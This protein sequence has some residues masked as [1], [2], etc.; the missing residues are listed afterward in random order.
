MLTALRSLGHEILVVGPR[1]A[2]PARMGNEIGWAR[3]LKASLPRALYEL[4]ELS[5]SVIALAQI[6]RAIRHFRPDVI[7]ERYNLFLVAGV[8]AKRRYR[9]PLVLEVNAPVVAERSRFGGL[10][11]TRLARWS[12]RFMWCGADRVLPVTQVLA[13]H[14][15]AVGVPPQRVIVIPNGVNEAHFAAASDTDA[16]KAVI[17]LPGRRV[18]GFTGFIREWHGVDRVIL[19]MASPA[20]P[21][22]VHL[23]IVGDGP[24][25][26]ELEALA[27][28]HRV[29]SRVTFTGVVP[30]ER[31]PEY[32]AAFDVALQPA[33]VPYAS[34]LKVF[35]YLA[36]GKAILAPRQPNIEEILVDGRNALLFDPA[37]PEALAAALDRIT[38]DST[39]RALLAGGAARTI[40]E[41]GLTW[42]D[43]AKR[44]TALCE[45]LSSETTP[46]AEDA[47]RPPTGRIGRDPPRR[48]ETA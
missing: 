17:G 36:L 25:R 46:K 34:P 48:K 39:L 26:A 33:V 22:D 23:L 31:V 35:E 37:H 18:L 29:E 11:L 32:V 7:Y 4:L 12:E 24:A 44:V 10:A 41:R 27:R 38:N 47:H 9:I 8:I 45:Y 5:Y 21:P 2:E 3:W 19:W 16:A 15:L 42:V 6:V 20:A 1:G 14:V 13:E 40:R 43:N 28:L 30:R